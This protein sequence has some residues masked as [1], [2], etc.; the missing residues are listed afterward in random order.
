MSFSIDIRN[1]DRGPAIQPSG[2]RTRASACAWIRYRSLHATG[3]V[4]QVTRRGGTELAPPRPWLIGRVRLAST[5]AGA[6]AA[7]AAAE[8]SAAQ[9]ETMLPKKSW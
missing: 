5:S 4:T 3:T 1:N 7:P 2:E 9:L 6:A 8:P